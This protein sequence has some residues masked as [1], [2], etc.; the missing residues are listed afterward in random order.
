MFLRRWVVAVHEQCLFACHAM[1][2]QA[3][4]PADHSIGC[5]IRH[6]QWDGAVVS[7]R[8]VD[9]CGHPWTFLIYVTAPCT[10]DHTEPL[11][12]L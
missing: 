9:D 6:T 4:S 7:V 12:S 2:G 1:P 8:E 5:S 10:L 11:H 3:S